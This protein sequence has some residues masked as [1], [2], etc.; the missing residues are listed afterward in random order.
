MSTA[1]EPAAAGFLSTD[2]SVIVGR[3]GHIYDSV[4]RHRLLKIPG[5]IIVTCEL[6]GGAA[7]GSR[8]AHF[9]SIAA[10]FKA[11]DSCQRV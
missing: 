2:R 6:A 1:K 11:S 10:V 7:I 5:V 4:I 8:K 9:S 3:D